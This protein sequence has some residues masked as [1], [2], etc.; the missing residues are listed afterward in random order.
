MIHIKPIVLFALSAL[1]ACTLQ[2]QRGPS[3]E[4]DKKLFFEVDVTHNDAQMLDRE[5][6]Q[7]VYV[8]PGYITYL[9]F[10]T[11]PPIESVDV[12]AKSLI[13]V[14]Y[15]PE[16]NAVTISPI[17]LAGHTNITI[18]LDGEPYVFA[19]S[20]R[21]KGDIDYRLTFTLPNVVDKNNLVK[22]GPPKK[23]TALDVPAFVR[24]VETYG[25]LAHPLKIHND[26]QHKELNKAYSWNSNI[27]YLSDAFGFPDDNLIVLRLTR[28]NLSSNANYLNVRQIKPFV[29]NSP[30]PVTAAI[31]SS[32]KGIL[33]P[34]Q[35]EQI[36]LL[37]QGYN[38]FADND[39]EV[40]L[41]PEA[42]AVSAIT[43]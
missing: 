10:P 35:M 33:Y 28:R 43:Q 36:Y 7:N 29:A 37:I 41:P 40:K 34:G 17:V 1:A 3:F 30:F 20:I 25:T 8:A 11:D 39:F 24:A 15:K 18:V 38:L 12:G 21:R 2:A 14:A 32:D 26:M 6:I 5:V 27:I 9:Q 16:L 23:P 4:S 31:Q 22:F 19:V 13:D 42:A